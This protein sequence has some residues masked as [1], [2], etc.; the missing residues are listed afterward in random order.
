MAARWITILSLN[1]RQFLTMIQ[2]IHSMGIFILPQV[3]Y[4]LT[5]QLH[6]NLNSPA[7]LKTPLY[8]HLSFPFPQF[9]E[10]TSI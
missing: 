9:V 7:D 2:I 3:L 8:L 4:I 1:T 10:E 5:L 6:R